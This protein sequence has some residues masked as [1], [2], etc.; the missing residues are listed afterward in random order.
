MSGCVSPRAYGHILSRHQTGNRRNPQKHRDVLLHG[1]L[2]C[3]THIKSLR[4]HL[5]RQG[6]CSTIHKQLLILV[7]CSGNVGAMYITT[8]HPC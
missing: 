2:M 5:Q 8:Q 7:A 4:P 1:R 3:I 6:V